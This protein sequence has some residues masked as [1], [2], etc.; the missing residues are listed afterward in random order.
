MNIFDLFITQP[1]F[2]LLIFVY[3]IVGDFGVAIIILT[4]LIRLALWPLVRKQM[5]QTKLMRSIQ[6][7][8][9]QI[10]AKAKGNRVLESQMMMDLYK[11]KDIKPF[12]SIFVLLIQL[13]IF[14]AVYNVVRNYD[15]F[16]ETYVYPFLQNVGQIP[17]LIADTPPPTF[18]GIDLTA[19]AVTDNGIAWPI[20][21]MAILAATLQF[22]QSRQT[23]TNTPQDN[24][25]SLR[26][27][28]AD[29][30]AGKDVDQ[31]EMAASMTQG[32]IYFF[33]IMTFFIAIM[34]PGAVVLYFVA[35]A[36]M[37]L[38]QQW[39]MLRDNKKPSSAD[40][41]NSAE[42]RAKNAKEAVIVKRPAKQMKKSVK[43]SKKQSN[44]QTT[45]RRIKA[46]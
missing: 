43:S 45:V 34:L 22:L 26:E 16:V 12:S 20:L 25:K 14:V 46:K 41:K 38:V 17:H 42:K 32:M 27:Y 21:I 6:P 8:I 15:S 1:I 39:F 40:K 23:M 44:T 19:V 9:K 4:I 35:S 33:P 18:F 3:N 29:A 37:A 36:A 30:A 11:K 2:N 7:E 31:S 5:N 10:K 13:P 24:K 28:F